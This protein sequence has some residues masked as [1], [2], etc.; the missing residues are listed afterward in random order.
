MEVDTR[1][2]SFFGDELILGS[3]LF[4]ILCLIVGLKLIFESNLKKNILYYLFLLLFLAVIFLSGERTALF[5]TIFYL[6]LFAMLKSGNKKYF[7]ILFF[8][9]L[10]LSIYSLSKFGGDPKNRIF[11][12]TFN[13]FNYRIKINENFKFHTYKV[14]PNKKVYIFS[15]QHET[16]YRTALNIF[17]DNKYF[18]IG[19]KNFREV[20]EDKKYFKNNFSCNTHPHNYYIQFLVETGIFVL[21]FLCLFVPH[22]FYNL[23]I[24]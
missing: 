16:L 6:I 8:V 14:D 10:I 24:Y 7:L 11:D 1:V 22:N 13:Q 5:L 20:C 17:K 3:Y 19:I 15:E 23:P 18:G 21:L 12:S 2:S 4:R 9:F